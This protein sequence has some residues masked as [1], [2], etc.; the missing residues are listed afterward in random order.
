MRTYAGC[1]DRRSD[2]SEHRNYPIP[3][4]HCVNGGRS[5]TRRDLG[6]DTIALSPTGSHPTRSRNNP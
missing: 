2:G 1:T 5:M 6:A 4:P 3:R